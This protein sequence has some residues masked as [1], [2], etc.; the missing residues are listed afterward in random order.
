LID[1]RD[2]NDGDGDVAMDVRGEEC[3]TV[4][5]I[6][7]CCRPGPDSGIKMWMVMMWTGMM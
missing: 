5:G 4:A 3:N 6:G 7:V 1:E 2:D